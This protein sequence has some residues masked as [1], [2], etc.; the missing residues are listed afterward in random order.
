MA[1]ECFFFFSFRTRALVVPFAFSVYVVRP[2]KS[3]N[4]YATNRNAT[5]DGQVDDEAADNAADLAIPLPP[6]QQQQPVESATVPQP[7]QPIPSNQSNNQPPQIVTVLVSAYPSMP[8]GVRPTE[9]FANDY[10]EMETVTAAAPI[11]PAPATVLTSSNGSVGGQSEVTASSQGVVIGPATVEVTSD[12]IDDD[13]ENIVPSS[14]PAMAN[15]SNSRISYM[16]GNIYR[17]PLVSEDYSELQALKPVR[18]LPK[19]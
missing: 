17:D 12:P 18:V 4:W 6:Q 19:V 8:I 9:V 10:G 13:A 7:L 15:Y 3:P 14:Q 16:D 2:F 11:V 5:Q 1:N